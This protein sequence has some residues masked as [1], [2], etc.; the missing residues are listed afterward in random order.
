[1][2]YRIEAPGQPVTYGD[3]RSESECRYVVRSSGLVLDMALVKVTPIYP[4]QPEPPLRYSLV[5]QEV[6]LTV[7][8]SVPRA[9]TAGDALAVVRDA[10]VRASSDWVLLEAVRL[11]DAKGKEE[12]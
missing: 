10:L 7:T 3:Y 5:R 4:G 6:T 9:A 1:M 2:R 8:V 11:G 12:G